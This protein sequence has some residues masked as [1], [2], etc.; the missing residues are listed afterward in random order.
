MTIAKF[1]ITAVICLNAIMAYPV[2]DIDCT[3]DRR[4]KT[5]TYDVDEVYTMVLN[6]GFQS[7][8]EFGRGETIQTIYVGDQYAWKITPMD[9]RLFIRP[10]VQYGFTNMTVITDRYSYEFDLVAKKLEPGQDKDVVY[11]MKFYYPR[12]SK[13][14]Q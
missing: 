2:G 8:I 6:Y 4:I 9:N 1:F 11:K 7:Y 5:Y 13:A 14:V 12:R 10:L 3:P